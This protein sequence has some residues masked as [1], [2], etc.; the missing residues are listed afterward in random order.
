MP[1]VN[2]L[3]SVSIDGNETV[4]GDERVSGNLTVTGLIST[5][6]GL[7]SIGPILSGGVDITNLWLSSFPADAVASVNTKIGVVVLSAEDVGALSLSGGVVAGDVVM[8]NLTAEDVNINK[9]LRVSGSVVAL[10]TLNLS[11]DLNTL[12]NVNTTSNLNVGG[13][14]NFLQNVNVLS[15]VDIATGLSASN[16]YISQSATIN[17]TLGLGTTN[18]DATKQLHVVGDVVVYGNLSANGTMSFANTLFTTTSALSIVN[19]GTGPAISVYQNGDQPIAAFYDHTESGI[20]LWVDGASDRPGFI[21]IKTETPNEELTVAGDVSATGRIT[22]NEFAGDGSLLTNV[23][24]VDAT[25]L[26]LAGGT[27]THD[28]SVGGNLYGTL[29]DWMTLVRGYKTTPVLS[30]HVAELSASVYGYT[31]ATTGTDVEYYRLIADDN[32]QDA[33]YTYFSGVST[34]T[35]LVA[36]KS[37]T[38]K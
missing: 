20:A 28:L 12:S 33:F 25:K 14:A 35:G 36:T 29:V 6:G 3:N 15:G 7:E 1:D 21:G 13:V 37:I 31:Y 8:Q 26:P 17:G 38:L 27:I 32:S 30:A 10:S 18:P 24:G 11:G 23:T 2:F 34:L 4:H 16:L 9:E 19:S 5:L 22:S